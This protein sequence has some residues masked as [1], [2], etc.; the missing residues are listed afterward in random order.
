MSVNNL[1]EIIKVAHPDFNMGLS[2]QKGIAI[3]PKL[4]AKIYFPVSPPENAIRLASAM[5]N[6]I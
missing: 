4:I 3:K 6:I 2:N 1:I 5:A